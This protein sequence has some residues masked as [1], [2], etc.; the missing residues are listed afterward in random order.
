MIMG[1][2]II[3]PKFYNYHKEIKQELERRYDCVVLISEV[4]FFNVGIYSKFLQRLSF[5]DSFLWYIYYKRLLRIICKKSINTIFVIRGYYLPCRLLDK[6]RTNFSTIKILY[7]QWDSVQNN[8]NS[9]N[10]SSRAD[11]SYTFDWEDSVRFNNSFT[12][13]PLYYHWPE[14]SI[15]SKPIISDILIVTSWSLYRSKLLREILKKLKGYNFNI[16]TYIYLPPLPFFK[17]ILMGKYGL[18]KG[19]NLFPINKFRYL[20]MLKGCKA[21]LDIPS[22]T[23]SGASI[24]V[25]EALSMKKKIITTNKTLSRVLFGADSPNILEYDDFEQYQD[26]LKKPFEQGNDMPKVVLS[27]R[28]WLKI[29]GI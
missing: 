20:Q 7:Y 15:A 13:L 14:E 5:L 28:E 27:L 6:L 22:P 24:R 2:L 16:N 9:L 3:S 1:V 25:I 4:P 17:Y 23:Q 12:Y 11:R 19:V 26:F 29:I 10:V 8:P 21:V 18:V